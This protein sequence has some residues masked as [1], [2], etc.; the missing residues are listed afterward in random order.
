[1]YW[2]KTL[3]HTSSNQKVFLRD[4][5]D[6]W[7]DTRDEEINKDRLARKSRTWDEGVN[8]LCLFNWRNWNINRAGAVCQESRRKR[9]GALALTFEIKIKRHERRLVQIS[10]WR[11]SLVCVCKRMN[12]VCWAV[13]TPCIYCTVQC[14][15]KTIKMKKDKREYHE[16]RPKEDSSVFLVTEKVCVFQASSPAARF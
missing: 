7:H 4:H 5:T 16:W 13:L 9:L 15:K 14:L 10:A 2:W 11:T 8:L 1:M 6:F 12:G 3:V